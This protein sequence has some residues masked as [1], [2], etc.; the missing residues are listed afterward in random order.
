MKNTIAV[1]IVLLLSSPLFAQENAVGYG[2]LNSY[3]QAEK[4]NHGLLISKNNAPVDGK[5]FTKLYNHQH[6]TN[7]K[8]KRITFMDGPVVFSSTPVEVSASRDP[9]ALR[10]ASLTKNSSTA[11]ELLGFAAGFV[12][13]ALAP[14]TYI[15]IEP[16]PVQA[17]L[18][19]TYRQHQQ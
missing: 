12:A 5:R 18:Q 19:S 11:L 8:T 9:L 13:P 3:L 7:K 10:P 6:P 16:S 14:K 17:Y 1:L 2:L 15:P 4:N